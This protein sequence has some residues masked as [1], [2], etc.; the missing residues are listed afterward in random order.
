[1]SETL[2]LRKVTAPPSRSPR[3]Q[4]GPVRAFSAFSFRDL[5]TRV[6]LGLQAQQHQVLGVT[7]AIQG[8][9]KTTIAAALAAAIAEDDA[10][11]GFG[12]D[13]NT[14][15]LIECN[16][17]VQPEDPRLALRPG[18]GLTQLLRGESTLEAAI[19]ETGIERLSILPAGEPAHN[20][21]LAIR[22]AA[23]P[24]LI[25]QLRPR[26]GL[27]I[28]DLPAVLNS[29]D[30]QVLARLADQ[31]VLVVRAGVTPAKLVR[32]ALDE[33]GEEMLL[34]IVLNDSQPDLPSWLDNRL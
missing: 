16:E 15:L 2:P 5:Y 11:I 8:E 31:L 29:T 3:E 17:G 6:L 13:P 20:F 7:S 32:E 1:M 12:R 18:P 21:P 26:F 10:L 33:L 28:L 24:D 14:T 27:I 30:T 19:Q 34:G 23:L 25:T 4:V 9:G 22:T